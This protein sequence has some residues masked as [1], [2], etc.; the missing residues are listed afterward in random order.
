MTRIIS[1]VGGLQ[2][3]TPTIGTAT[4]GDTTASVA[5]TASSYIGKGTITYT[6]TSSPGGLTATGASSPLTVTG[7]TNGTAYTFTVVGNT[8]YG[9][10]SVAS[11]AS[12][13]ITPATQSSYESI[14]TTTVGSGGSSTITFSSI[15]ATYKHLEVRLIAR[16]ALTG[17]GNQD[18]ILMRFNSDTGNNYVGHQLYGDGSSTGSGSLGGTPPV[19]IMYPAYVTSNSAIASSYGVG[20]IDILDYA[21]TNKYKVMRSLNGHDNNGNGFILHRTSLW[22]STSAIS[23]ITFTFSSSNYMQY[24]Q[25]ALYGIKGA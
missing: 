13:S 9:V 20:I 8:N 22:M 4:A 10:A 2:P 11:A 3:S 19:N 14:A 6:A 25:F 1:I 17:S 18:D 12:N 7:L 5:F 21:N 15:P 23:S 16:S 24:S